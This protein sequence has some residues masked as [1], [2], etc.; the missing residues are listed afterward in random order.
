LL[1]YN[2]SGNPYIITG[3]PSI[4]PGR[5]G[6]IRGFELSKNASKGE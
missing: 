2:I 3:T 6:S 5:V 4:L 1:N